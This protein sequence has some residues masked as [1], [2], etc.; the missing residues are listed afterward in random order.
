MFVLKKDKALTLREDFYFEG[1]EVHQPYGKQQPFSSV[2]RR[3]VIQSG[4]PILTV[5]MGKK[6]RAGTGRRTILQLS[7]PGPIRGA[8]GAA[9]E[10]GVG[11]GSEGGREKDIRRRVTRKT[12]SKTNHFKRNARFYSESKTSLFSRL[13]SQF[14]IFG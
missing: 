11:S 5:A 4:A 14:V 7:P 3:A 6:T 2:P 9:R 8:T 13:T 1:Q 10:D 12:W